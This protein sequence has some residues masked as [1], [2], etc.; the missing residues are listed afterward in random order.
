MKKLVVLMLLSAILP[1]VSL[2]GDM[3]GILGKMLSFFAGNWLL[4]PAIFLIIPLIFSIISF[5]VFK[6]IKKTAF[7]EYL[8]KLN[9]KTFVVIYV[10][11][12]VILIISGFTVFGGN[13]V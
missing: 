9:K 5:L 10:V 2:I 4:F 1:V 3:E 7:G 6:L 12:L 13:R 8:P 11:T